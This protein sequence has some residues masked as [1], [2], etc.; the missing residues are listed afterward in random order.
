MGIWDLVFIGT[1]LISSLL[2][3]AGSVY[4]GIRYKY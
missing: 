4:Q 3:L 1:P 2:L